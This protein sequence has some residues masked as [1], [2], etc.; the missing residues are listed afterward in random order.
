MLPSSVR[1]GHEET[2]TASPPL[3]TAMPV[4]V[5]RPCTSRQPA[6]P[7]SIASWLAKHG[8]VPCGWLS[9]PVAGERA[10]TA[11]DPSMPT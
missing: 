10:N 1:I 5:S 2:T 7:L 4:V 8:V 6:T 9:A 11:S 3:V